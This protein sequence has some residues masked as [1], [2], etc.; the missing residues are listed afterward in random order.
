MKRL[1]VIAL[2]IVCGV[3]FSDGFAQK[4][5]KAELAETGKEELRIQER[6]KL[7]EI[8]EQMHLD[9]IKQVERIRELEEERERLKMEDSLSNPKGQLPGYEEMEL[10]CQEEAISTDEYYGAWA[11]SDEQFSQSAAVRDA[12]LKAKIELAKQIGGDGEDGV[13]I[14]DAK[15]VCR[16]I[17]LDSFGNYI[18][19]VAIRMPKN[20]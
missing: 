7:Q 20:K 15:I 19:Y 5:K 13:L 12:M 16:M 1:I 10:P 8:R 18:A 11:V 17:A 2:A 9:S 6:K 14:D 4:Q 3:V